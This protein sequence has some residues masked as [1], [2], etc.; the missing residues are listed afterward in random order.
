M[1][2]A[3]KRKEIKKEKTDCVIVHNYE[4]NILIRRFAYFFWITMIV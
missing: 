2:K 1:A 4:I 3:L